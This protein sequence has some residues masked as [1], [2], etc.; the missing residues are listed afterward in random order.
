VLATSFDTSVQ[1]NI[2]VGNGSSM[3]GLLCGGI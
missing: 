3:A 1:G 2:A